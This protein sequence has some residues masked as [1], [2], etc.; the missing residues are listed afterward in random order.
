MGTVL[1][2]SED[3]YVWLLTHWHVLVP[4]SHDWLLLFGLASWVEKNS[5]GIIA[6]FLHLIIIAGELVGAVLCLVACLVVS[7]TFIH[8]MPVAPT[9]LQS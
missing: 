8:V 7:L 3:S 9:H 6:V 1:I 2:Q 5:F 4:V